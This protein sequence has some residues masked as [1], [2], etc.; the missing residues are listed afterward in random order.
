MRPARRLGDRARHAPGQ[1]ELVE[2]GIGVGLQDARVARQVAAGM[3]AAAVRRVEKYRRR[4]LRAAERP[5]VADIGPQPP[6]ARPALGQHRHRGVVAMQSLGGQHVLA[7]ERQQRRQ[8]RGA[9]AD[10]SA[11]G[12]DVEVDA[13]A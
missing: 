12:R 7:D 9:G 3:L 13:R 4:W 10:P 8:G 2:P 5:V 11:E 6:D 1:V